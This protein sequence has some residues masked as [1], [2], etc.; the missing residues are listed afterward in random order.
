MWT[1]PDYRNRTISTM[2]QRKVVRPNRSEHKLEQ[3]LAKSY[4][5]VWKYTG[6]GSVVLNGFTPDFTNING[7]KL[8]IELFGDYWHSAKKVRYWHETELGRIMAY[9][10]LGFRCLVIWE[11]ELV[12]PTKVIQKVR[13]FLGKD[14]GR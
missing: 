7:K 1:D 8:L 14:L 3:L 10:S 2:A 4:P 13:A 11:A 12:D 5:G 6:D 9:N